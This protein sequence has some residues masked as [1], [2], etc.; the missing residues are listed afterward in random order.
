MPLPAAIAEFLA[1]F[2]EGSYPDL[3]LDSNRA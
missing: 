1:G 2:D 3:E